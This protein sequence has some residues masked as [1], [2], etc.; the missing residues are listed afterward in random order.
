MRRGLA[1]VAVPLLLLA[2]V[3]TAAA[4]PSEGGIS[5]D[6]VEYVGFVPFEA[7]TATG[8]HVFGKY[9]YV[10]TWRSFS[11]YDISKPESPEL[12]SLTPFGFRFENEDVATDGKIMLFSEE[13]PA[14][15]LHVYDVEDKSNPVEIATVAGAGNHTATCILRCRYSYGSDGDIVDLR[16]PVKAELVGNWHKKI[17]TREKIHDVDEYKDGFIVTSPYTGPMQIVDVRDPLQP[18]VVT[19]GAPPEIYS[20]PAQLGAG[21]H[22]TGWP[23]AGKDDLLMANGGSNLYQG[24]CDSEARNFWTFDA[25]KWASKGVLRYRDE[26][27][28]GNGSVTEGRFPAS[29][30]SPHWFDAHPTFHN[31]GLVTMGYYDNGTRFVDVSSKG[32][33]KESGWFVPYGGVT[34]AAY[35]ITDEIVYS[36]DYARGFDILRYDSKR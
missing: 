33:I 36:I 35:W 2:G 18:K 5:S 34:S 17:G 11:I 8:S 14:D 26:Y 20:E 3:P 27:N 25:S 6:N 28:P 4:G 29:T 9:L 15:E 7:G 30:C 31:G 24:T 23:R 12:V 21:V 19:S 13:A 1:I 32:R 10:T 16:D 22:Q